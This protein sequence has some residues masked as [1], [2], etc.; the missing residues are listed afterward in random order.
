MPALTADEKRTLAEINARLI[1]AQEKDDEQVPSQLARQRIPLYYSIPRNTPQLTT[2]YSIPQHIHLFQWANDNDT[3]KDA[4]FAR[5]L[6]WQE[7]RA[8]DLIVAG[9]GVHDGDSEAAT[10]I[11]GWRL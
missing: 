7:Q 5:L 10:E 6:K 1:D 2:I 11:L 3:K 9:A 4:C 8:S